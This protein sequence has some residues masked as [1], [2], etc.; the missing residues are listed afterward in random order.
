MPIILRSA[1]TLLLAAL[2]TVAVAQTE[3]APVVVNESG[4][5]FEQTCTEEGAFTLTGSDNDATISGPCSTVTIEGSNNKVH[6]ART[7]AIVIDGN[8]NVVD[9][10]SGALERVAPK[11][12]TKGNGNSVITFDEA[13]GRQ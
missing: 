2:A 6:I 5:T 8:N 10:R 4:A 1:Q 13:L 7:G 12:T 11:V 3:S 9:W